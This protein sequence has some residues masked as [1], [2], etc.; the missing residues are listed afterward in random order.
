MR[1]KHR[2]S[3]P[4]DDIVNIGVLPADDIVNIEV[5]PADDII[6]LVIYGSCFAITKVV[7]IS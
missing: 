3:V 5:L 2:G 7:I 6:N 4:G 1:H